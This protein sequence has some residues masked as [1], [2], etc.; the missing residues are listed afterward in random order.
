MLILHERI[1]TDR[2]NMAWTR[3][4]AVIGLRDM[5]AFV[6]PKPKPRLEHHEFQQKSFSSSEERTIEYAYSKDNP[7]TQNTE[8]EIHGK[9]IG[10]QTGKRETSPLRTDV[11]QQ[12]HVRRRNS[13]SSMPSS[14][15]TLFSKLETYRQPPH[16]AFLEEEFLSARYALAKARK[17]Q[18]LLNGPLLSAQPPFLTSTSL[19]IGCL[20]EEAAETDHQGT[21]DAK[22]A[23]HASDNGADTAPK[24]SSIS[25]ESP[26]EVK[27]HFVTYMR[28]LRDRRVCGSEREVTS[29]KIEVRITA[30]EDDFHHQAETYSLPRLKLTHRK[31]V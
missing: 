5:K 14:T 3:D 2:H 21:A 28:R 13:P 22:T 8:L 10:S 11:A 24:S 26:P 7:P 19:V 18:E 29:A 23:A 20:D 17:E 31:D 30:P 15:N 12:D 27:S 4:K 16:H 9:C 1:L 6:S 25:T